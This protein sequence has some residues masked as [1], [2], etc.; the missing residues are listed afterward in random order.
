[1]RRLR[2][3]RELWNYGRE[4]FLLVWRGTRSDS[5]KTTDEV[6]AELDALRTKYGLQDR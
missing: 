6:M 1:M 5:G 4:G 3:L 2:R